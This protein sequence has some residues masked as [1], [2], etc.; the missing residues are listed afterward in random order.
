MWVGVAHSF[1]LLV[2]LEVGM[3]GD[4]YDD[5]AMEARA[6]KSMSDYFERLSAD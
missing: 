6:I 4:N 1:D 3:H 2:P 5:N